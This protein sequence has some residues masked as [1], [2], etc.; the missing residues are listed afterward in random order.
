[1][2][3]PALNVRAIFARR[4]LSVASKRYC[5]DLKKIDDPVNGDGCAEASTTGALV[6][7]PVVGFFVA[8]EDAAQAESPQYADGT[9][10]RIQKINEAER[11]L[12]RR[13][14]RRD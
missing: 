14:P 5:F 6:V 1:M 13:M 7:T 10:E 9:M 11:N 12:E 4:A 3:S 8:P 2:E